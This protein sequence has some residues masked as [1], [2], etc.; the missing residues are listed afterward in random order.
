MNE[1]SVVINCSNLPI[2]GFILAF[3]DNYGNPI[4][5]DEAESYMSVE[6]LK[7]P[8]TQLV[9]CHNK[10]YYTYT[11]QEENC[12]PINPALWTFRY[13]TSATLR[14]AFRLKPVYRTPMN[15]HINMFYGQHEKPQC[16]LGPVVSHAI[17][18]D[19]SRKCTKTPDCPG[20][21]SWMVE[22]QECYYREDCYSHDTPY[23]DV[24]NVDTDYT[25]PRDNVYDYEHHD[26][27]YNYG[28][29]YGNSKE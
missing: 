6:I 16:T 25:R 1:F 10:C 19:Q 18:E 26:Y 7:C 12:M 28:Y 23:E 9:A 24:V 15:L 27:G 4:L 8:C 21:V 17:C 5:F 29:E 2:E 14:L 13:P 22:L 3:V 11:E 20:F